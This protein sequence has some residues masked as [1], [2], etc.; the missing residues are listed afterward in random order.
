[1]QPAKT[2]T[3]IVKYQDPLHFTDMMIRFLIDGFCFSHLI[4]SRYGQ[5]LAVKIKIL[6]TS[7]TYERYVT[8]TKFGHPLEP[9]IFSLFLIYSLVFISLDD[10]RPIFASIKGHGF[11]EE[12]SC[13]FE[14]KNLRE[15]Y[16]R[17]R[18][19]SCSLLVVCF[20]FCLMKMFISLFIIVSTP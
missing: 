7:P 17:E 20:P 14:K 19:R 1:M 13:Y 8:R 10:S 5:N 11:E 2:Q 4:C 15:K 16:L 12:S 18:E 6:Y 3:F 9:P